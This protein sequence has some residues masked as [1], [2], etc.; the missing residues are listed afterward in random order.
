MLAREMII[1]SAKMSGIFVPETDE[2]IDLKHDDSVLATAKLVQ[3]GRSESGGG[4]GASV[5]TMHSRRG[6]DS[7]SESVLHDSERDRCF[8]GDE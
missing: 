2:E 8:K 5:V 4:R 7:S 3:S 6:E 1:I